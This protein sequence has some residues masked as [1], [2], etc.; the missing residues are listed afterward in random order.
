MKWKK[1]LFILATSSLA[2]LFALVSGAAVQDGARATVPGTDHGNFVS[3]V[4]N[5]FFP[6]QPGTT[7]VYEGATDGIPTR[8]EVYVTHDTKQILGVTCTVVRDR[9]FEDGAL[10]EETFDWYAQDADGNVW[11]FGE[12]AKVL[13]PNTGE[14]I[15]TEGS[16]EAG[17]NGAQPGVVMLADPKVGD[18]YRQEHAPDVAEDTAQVRSLD[19]AACVAYDCYSDVLKTKEWSP[20]DK[21]VVENK[22]YAADVGLILALTV[23]GGDELSE[24]VSIT[25]E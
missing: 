12:D 22:Y 5:R 21:G 4:D 24:L 10:V 7:Y 8:D 20:L 18:R 17:V 23:K 11:Y 13:D 14:V 25:T 9:A 1:H 19:E 6:L 16:W 3:Q 2:M 15:S